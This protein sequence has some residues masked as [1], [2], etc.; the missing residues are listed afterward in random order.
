MSETSL[1]Y[2][3]AVRIGPV[4]IGIRT[5][6]PAHIPEFPPDIEV[7][8]LLTDFHSVE[9][10][11]Y[12]ER[13]DGHIHI[14][15]TQGDPRIERKGN[16]I[17]CQG[18]YLSLAEK[19]SDDRRSFWGNLGLLYHFTLHLLETR[20]GIY[21][22][23]ACA[24]FEPGTRIL[25]VA[26]GGAGSGKTV[27]LLSGIARGLRLFS[28]ETV[29][30]QIRDDNILWHMGSLVDNIRWG[31]LIDDFPQFQPE[32]DSPPRRGNVWQEKIALDLS[33]HRCTEESLHSPSCIILFPRIEQGREEFL[34][35]PV[36]DTDKAAQLMF[37]NIAEKTA[38]SFVLYDTIAVPG[39]E[40]E[41]SAQTRL[42]GLRFFARHPSVG[43]VASVLTDPE[44][45][46][47]NLLR[48]NQT[49][50]D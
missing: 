23:H 46:W 50:G 45:C 19:A 20:H 34:M 12:S 22:F 18:P 44:H 11:P 49:Q 3:T 9:V 38:Q 33:D 31:T 15:E 28:T 17:T 4:Q 24:L 2:T 27:F 30:L 43:L 14:R 41:D 5:N 32:L 1:K 40:S 26:A 42:D 35:T 29:H 10:I 25:Y 39:F 13:L 37:D 16:R 36:R 7:K 47:G 6:D 48:T 21:S 8:S